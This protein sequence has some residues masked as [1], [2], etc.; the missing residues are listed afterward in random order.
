MRTFRDRYADPHLALA[1]FEHAR[2][3][4]IASYVFGCTTPA[5]NELLETRWACFRDLRGIADALEE[6]RVNGVE[7]DAATRK[8]VERL[9]REVGERNLWQEESDLETGEVFTLLKKIERLSV[10]PILTHREASRPSKSKSKSKKWG[11]SAERWKFEDESSDNYHF[12]DWDYKPRKKQS[13]KR[14][15]SPRHE[16][17]KF[18]FE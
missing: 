2:R 1:I 17:V 8:I 12:G 13:R 18:A 14:P 4:S 11:I 9:R 7:P 16:P 3:L 6:M 10:K 15:P 5:Y